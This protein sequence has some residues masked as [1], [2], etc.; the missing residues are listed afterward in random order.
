LSNRFVGVMGGKKRKNNDVDSAI[1]AKKQQKKQSVNNGVLRERLA[2][3]GLF[4]K[5]T[6]NNILKHFLAPTKTQE[7]FSNTFEKTYKVFKRGSDERL[8]RVCQNL[9]NKE[10]FEAIAKL[11]KLEPV[12]DFNLMKYAEGVRV[13]HD[14][15]ENWPDVDIPATF[16]DY[17]NIMQLV[18]DQRYTMQFHQPQRFCDDFW[19]VIAALEEAFGALVGANIYW[20][21]KD[22]QGLAPHWDSIDAFVLQLNGTKK[23]KLWKNPEMDLPPGDSSEDMQMDE[24][25]EP[26]AEIE[27]EP[28]DMLY[29]PRGIVHCAHSGPEESSIHVTFS[30]NENNSGAHWLG[31][32]FN[33][34][35]DQMAEEHQFLREST[36][37]NFRDA[38]S[39]VAWLKATLARVSELITE[40][41]V[42]EEDPIKKDFYANRLPPYKQA[43]HASKLK[44]I[45]LNCMVRLRNKE[46]IYIYRDDHIDGNQDVLDED[47]DRD[48]CCD[49]EGGCC[50][51]P[52]EEEEGGCCGGKEEVVEG[53]MSKNECSSVEKE[54]GIGEEE[55]ACGGCCGDMGEDKDENDEDGEDDDDLEGENGDE[56][57]QVF[58]MHSCQN[59]RKTHMVTQ[60]TPQCIRFPAALKPSLDKLMALG[61]NDFL[62]LSDLELPATEAV[63]FAVALWAEGLLSTKE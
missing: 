62:L 52:E 49:D 38:K 13:N 10:R 12:R 48:P 7:F 22:T 6:G 1:K 50:G 55:G 40:E 20:T 60:S 31:A 35:I 41:D 36:P 24:L 3:L 57:D 59:D 44:Q 25:G 15:M 34:M 14:V 54:S 63:Q 32:N 29:M 45:D 30:V 19:R 26:L 9:F 47:D 18:N 37:R 2:D 16:S 11:E 53:D 33:S 51:E 17:A 28:G 23:W 61:E 42:P 4:Q 46:H 5:E 43:Q 8:A 21:P 39:R 56:D 27:L 58:F